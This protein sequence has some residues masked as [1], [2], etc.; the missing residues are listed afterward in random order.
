MLSRRELW[1]L[2]RNGWLYAGALVTLALLV[3][4]IWWNSEHGL[5]SI[6]FQLFDRYTGGGLGGLSSS[7][8]VSFLVLSPL[9][10][11]PVLLPALAVFLTSR[12]TGGLGGMLAG[13]GKAAFAVSTLVMAALSLL[14]SVAP[15]WNLLAYPVFLALAYQHMLHRYLLLAHLTLGL[16]AATVIT[17]YYAGFPL[18]NFSGPGEAE[19]SRSHGWE[20][21]AARAEA[22][23]EANG[24]AGIA[25]VFY[26]PSAK[27]AF[28]AARASVESFSPLPDQF[29]LWRD[30]A[31]TRGRDYVLVTDNL[32]PVSLASGQ[33]EE[34]VALETF[35]PERFGLPVATYELYLARGYKG[36]LP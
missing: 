29:D 16:V 18:T 28:G 9:L 23:R 22:L 5:V 12:R 6:R 30:E 8:L 26:G 32:F 36:A 2:L 17:F 35:V 27:L 21:I 7:G 14:V 34:I 4:V 3:P 24:A 31:A 11:S 1:P 20:Q 13:I 15:H 10:L 25:G 33:F 19:A